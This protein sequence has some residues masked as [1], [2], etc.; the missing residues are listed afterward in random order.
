MIQN[1][2]LEARQ[3]YAFV[4]RNFNLVKR[5][6]GWEVV[7][8]FYSIAN[9]L[10]VT[11]IG[12][13]A[14]EITGQQSLDTNFLITYLL[15]GTLVWHFLSGIFNNVSEMIAWERWE[16]TIEYTFMAP[17]RRFNQMI[18][19]TL[20][21]VLY[22]FMFTVVIGVVVASFFDLHFYG[23]DFVSAAGI[24]LVGSVSFVGI[25]VV[26]SI[27]PLLY[28]ERGAQM[29]NIVQALFLLVSGVYY[30]V[31]VL[32]DWLQVLSRLS[33]ATYVLE[34]MRAALLPD[35]STAAPTHYVW[36]LLLMGIVMLPLGVYLFQRA[37]RYTKRTG[38][39]KRNG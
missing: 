37:E 27:L 2:Q 16:G 39:L 18:G 24:L 11:F 25:G 17:V 23:A 34:G 38:K 36:P 22:A 5:Y 21:A 7:W 30:P 32:P 10:S 26:A 1:L 29:T 19:Q 28:P 4:A 12:A 35:Q 13:G 6:W 14:S 9:A 33:P 20:F 3:S 15:V 31:S 8:L